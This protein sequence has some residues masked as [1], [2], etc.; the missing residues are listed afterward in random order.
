MNQLNSQGNQLATTTVDVTRWCQYLECKLA[1]S[2][3][4]AEFFVAYTRTK[5]KDLSKFID[6]ITT[7]VNADTEWVNT[8]VDVWSKY[9][10]EKDCKSMQQN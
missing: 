4:D 6:N 10:F 1:K 3:R 9:C 5:G 2:L 8:W 7:R